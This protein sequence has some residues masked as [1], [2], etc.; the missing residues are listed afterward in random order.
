MFNVSFSEQCYPVMQPLIANR[1]SADAYQYVVYLC[2]ESIE[3]IHCCQYTRSGSEIRQLSSALLASCIAA[4][5]LKL[6]LVL[7]VLVEL[8]LDQLLRCLILLL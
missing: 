7:V 5:F 3:Q 8:L 6:L 2:A 4:S 1:N